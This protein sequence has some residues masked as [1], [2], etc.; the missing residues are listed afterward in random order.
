M[1]QDATQ[2]VLVPQLQILTNSMTTMSEEWK[3]IVIITR[4]HGQPAVP[5]TLG[6]ELCVFIDRISKELKELNDFVVSTKFGGAVGNMNAHC[7]AYPQHD[8]IKFAT[9]FVAS[10]D[11]ERQKCTT[12]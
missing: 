8:W 1:L 3:K 10:F 5:S 7:Y 11:M 4:T 12:D 9:N 2:N 6:K